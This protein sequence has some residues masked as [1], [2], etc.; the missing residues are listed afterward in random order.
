MRWGTSAKASRSAGAV[1]ANGL[2]VGGDALG[3]AGQHL[4][5]A[6]PRR[7]A[8]TPPS[9]AIHGSAFAPA[10]A[11]GDLLDQQA[12]DQ[13]GFVGRTGGD[14][15][16]QRA[17]G[18]RRWWPCARA[19]AISS[20]AGCISGQWKGAE[21]FSGMARAPSSL[22]FSMAAVHRRLVARDHHVAGVVVVGHDADAD[23]RAGLGASLRPGPGRSWADQRG[24]GALAHRHGAL[25]G[26]AAQLQ[27]AG[28]VGQA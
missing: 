2:G 7:S 9:S 26:L 5:G 28:G 23:L 27:Q 18:A 22:A 19:S 4:A 15:G 11:A 6:R 3:H 20:A 24:H 10:H 13:L 1:Q 16:D 14:V 12:A 8:V 21:T 25:H 17:R